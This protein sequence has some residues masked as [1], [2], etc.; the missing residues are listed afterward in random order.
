MTPSSASG[1]SRLAAAAGISCYSI[2]GLAPLCFQLAG[3]LGASPWEILAHRSLWGAPA[4][5]AFVLAASGGRQALAVLR[6]RRTLA[7]L[8]LAAALIGVNWSVFI[9]AVNSG[10]VLE[11]S[12]G[13]YVL[14][15][16]N[17]ATGWALFRERLDRA[18]WIAI[19]LAAAGVALQTFALGRL[20]VVSLALAVSF[21]AYAVVKKRV[22]VPA[23]TGLLVECA[24]LAVPS[25][26]FVAWL[27]AR[28]LGHFGRAP[29]LTAVLVACGPITAVPLMLFAWAARRLP[30]SAMGFLQFIAPTMT[31]AIGVMQ[32]EPFSAL[33]GASFALIWA[34]VA[35][36]AL[37]ALRRGRPEPAIVAAVKAA[38][39]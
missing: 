30:L 24:L 32:G 20:P 18:A 4:A 17:M 5:L 9:W 16:I 35:V 15:L 21:G 36:F 2:W 13:Y 39:E 12:L 29:A 38:A 25:A 6:E 19:G 31:F 3:R 26:V 27:E 33:R 11:T 7:W 23:H 37:A 34:G 28:G 10:R 22:S 1:G 14:P 8:A